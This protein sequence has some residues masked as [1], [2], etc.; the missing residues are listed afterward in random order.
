MTLR[1]TS[2]VAFLLAIVILAAACQDRRAGREIIGDD[3][4]GRSVSSPPVPSPL[5]TPPHR[6][7][8]TPSSGA[9]REAPLT[10]EQDGRHVPA[11]QARRVLHVGD[12]MVPL[13][14]N[15]LRPVVQQRGGAYHI[16]S[17]VSSSTSTWASRR[18]L[19]EATYDYD[20]DLILIS[21]G[22]NELFA[23]PT[24]AVQRDIQQIVHQTRRR[25]CLWIA[26][27]AWKPDH[28]FLALL[29]ANLGHCRYFDSTQLDLPRMPDGRHPSWTGGHRWATAV[30][31]AL[32]GTEPVPK[33]ARP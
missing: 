30:W 18:L 1:L 17:E 23:P 20:P 3:T 7:Q 2:R 16:I 22:S 14:A 31:N 19:H 27:P 24:R 6:P 11:A 25:P 5:S 15:Y 13:V 10:I 8:P 28:G 9:E 4:P 32:G 33:R 21:L 26:P 12:S 29:K